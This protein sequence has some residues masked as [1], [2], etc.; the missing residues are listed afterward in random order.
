MQVFL[1]KEKDRQ[2]LHIICV[3]TLKH[4]YTGFCDINLWRKLKKAIINV[5][6]LIVASVAAVILTS[7]TEFDLSESE[8][9]WIFRSLWCVIANVHLRTID[10]GTVLFTLF[11]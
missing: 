3:N 11:P 6:G 10:W 5:C 9:M 1:N 8:A 7:V 2:F 4:V